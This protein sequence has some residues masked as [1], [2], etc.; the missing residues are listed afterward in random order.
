MNPKRMSESGLRLRLDQLRS[1][2]VRTRLDGLPVAK[3]ERERARVLARLIERV[4]QREAA[5]LRAL[6]DAKAE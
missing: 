6:R 5:A 2:I 1:A 4:Q 3:L